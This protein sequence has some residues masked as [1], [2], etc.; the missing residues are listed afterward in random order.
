MVDNLDMESEAGWE[1]FARGAREVQDRERPPYI[2]QFS[3]A[4]ELTAYV[5]RGGFEQVQAHQRSPLVVVTGIK[6][7]PA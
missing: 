4:A 5:R 3:T 2:G 1:S 6:P 7:R